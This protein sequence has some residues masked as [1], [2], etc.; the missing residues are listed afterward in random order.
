MKLGSVPN[1]DL[2]VNS[3]HIPPPL[4]PQ[5]S[6]FQFLDHFP[7]F[8]SSVS[9]TQETSTWVLFATWQV[10]PKW[11]NG[12]QPSTQHMGPPWPTIQRSCKDHWGW[13]ILARGR[14][15]RI[16]NCWPPWKRSQFLIH[17]KLTKRLNSIWLTFQE[18]QYYNAY[19][20]DIAV[21]NIFFG[22]STVF[23]ELLYVQYITSNKLII[24][25]T[26]H[27]EFERSQKMTW[28]DFVSNLGGLCGLCLGI[29]FISVTE[30][31]YWFTI[32]LFRGVL[33]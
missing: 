23:G 1:A 32:R 24:R 22:G 11:P 17:P 19:E 13:N 9:V 7:Q 6:G 33:G 5:N 14:L 12:S 8:F 21:V 29:S 27:S 3:P 20:K 15:E 18:N 16:V 26:S 25:I 2:I 30:I 28:L 10:T 4:P 31:V